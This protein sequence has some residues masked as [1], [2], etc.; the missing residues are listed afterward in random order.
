MATEPYEMLV[1]LADDRDR[2]WIVDAACRD[3]D[4]DVF[5]PE[6]GMTVGRTI[7]R[8]CQ[9]C[10]VRIACLDYGLEDEHGVWGGLVPDERRYV[11]TGGRVVIPMTRALK[12]F[13]ASNEGREYVSSRSLLPAPG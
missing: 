7:R 5:Y 6:Q 3:I 8:L 12:D 11:A 10:P 4:T 2:S 9:R 1:E 13:L